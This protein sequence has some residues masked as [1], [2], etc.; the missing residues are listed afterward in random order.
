MLFWI[1]ALTLCLFLAVCGRYE[2]DFLPALVLLAVTG[3][4]SLERAL[5]PTSEPGLAVRPVWRR[6][7]RLAWSLLLGFSVAFN[8]LVS[9]E[10]CADSDFNLGVTL[11]RLGKVQE[12]IGHYEQ[13]LRRNPDFCTAHNNLGSALLQAGKATEAIRHYEQA[14]RI[15]PDFAEAH[16]NLGNALDELDRPQE[17]VGHYEQALRIKPDYADAHYNFGVTLEK[18]GR[19]QEA[20]QHYE[21]A[22]RIK[23]DFTQAQ[24]ALARLQASH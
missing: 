10:Q 9:V 21:Q 2:V 8:L 5:A 12:A 4:L 7:A 6:A 17:A 13:A 20:I 11:M 14:L 3:I 1:C 24:T 16:N 19:T 18:L 22:R 15:K 23:P